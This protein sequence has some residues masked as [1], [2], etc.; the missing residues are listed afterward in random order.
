MVVSSLEQPLARKMKNFFLYL[1]NLNIME[2]FSI[3]LLHYWAIL[4][5]DKL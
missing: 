1:L 2:I 3:F 4:F 5:L